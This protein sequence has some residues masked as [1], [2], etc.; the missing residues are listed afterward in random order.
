SNNSDFGD[1]KEF[2][3]RLFLQPFKR[4]SLTALQGIGFGVGGSYSQIS[5]NT[6]GLPNTTG[7]TL[8]GYATDG[9]QQFFAYNP[10]IGTVVANGPHWRFSPQASYLK[11]PFGLLGEYALSHQG[12]LNNATLLSA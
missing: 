11:G 12:V 4:T 7:G 6:L 2:A 8:P 1:D 3:A 10:V 5:S 9:Q